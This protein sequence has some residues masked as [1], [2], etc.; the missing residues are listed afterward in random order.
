MIPTKMTYK[1]GDFEISIDEAKKIIFL[2]EPSKQILDDC[3]INYLEMHMKHKSGEEFVF[4]IQRK[5]KK[6]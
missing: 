6:K 3:K 5:E 4:T 2:A 1:N